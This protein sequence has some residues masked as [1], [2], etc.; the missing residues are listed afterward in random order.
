MKTKKYLNDSPSFQNIK[1]SMKSGQIK[2]P[3]LAKFKKGD[4][5]FILLGMRH[6]NE[7]SNPHF[8]LINTTVSNFAK[9]HLN[10]VI[11]SE[12]NCHDADLD[13]LDEAIHRVGESG[14]THWFAHSLNMKVICP[15][16][17]YTEVIEKLCWQFKP[18][19][20][21]HTMIEIAIEPCKRAGS[22]IN[23]QEGLE[24]QLD[25][26][27]KHKELIKAVGFMPSKEWFQ[28]YEPD[29]ESVNI[30]GE[31]VK[32]R[33]EAILVKIVKLWESGKSILMVYGGMH[34]LRLVPAIEQLV[35][36]KPKI[37]E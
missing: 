20:V 37:I 7:V 5:E 25:Y 23:A 3:Y 28:K 2:F 8:E 29:P 10:G 14:A 1:A 26:W 22:L 15:E 13:S 32:I 27:D 31:M 34:V 24:H 35:G 9:R 12:N 18:Q 6:S 36:T 16:M 19:D 4:R 21:V 11:I 33:D 30:I 17:P